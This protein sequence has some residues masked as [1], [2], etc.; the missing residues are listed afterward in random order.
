[1]PTGGIALVTP[2]EETALHLDLMLL[3]ILAALAIWTEI[4][5]LKAKRRIVAF[6]APRDPEAISVAGPR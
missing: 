5:K 6:L 1:L 2:S 3:L 4:D